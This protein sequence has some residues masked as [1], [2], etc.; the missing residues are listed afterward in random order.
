LQFQ[1]IEESH[2]KS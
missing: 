2:K 1:A